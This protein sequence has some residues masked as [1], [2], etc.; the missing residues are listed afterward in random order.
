MTNSINLQDILDAL[1]SN[2]AVQTKLEALK[3]REEALSVVPEHDVE[4]TIIPL[5]PMNYFGTKVRLFASCDSD[6][7]ITRLKIINLSNAS[8][9]VISCELNGTT[10]N[11]AYQDIDTLLGKVS[12]VKGKVLTITVNGTSTKVLLKEN[13]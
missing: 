4:Y 11:L 5:Y 7:A 1:T 6:F 9:D 2:E 8:Q 10:Y 3:A 12:E 13:V